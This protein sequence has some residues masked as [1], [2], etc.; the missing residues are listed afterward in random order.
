MF[1]LADPNFTALAPSQ[2]DSRKAGRFGSVDPN[3]LSAQAPE[4]EPMLDAEGPQ[5][6]G[7]ASTLNPVDEPMHD[8]HA[9]VGLG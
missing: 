7:D 9:E 5:G 6:P 2:S 4:D 8:A 3:S 1:G